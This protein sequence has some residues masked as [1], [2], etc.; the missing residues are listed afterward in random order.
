MI[1][2][3]I[4]AACEGVSMRSFM[5]KVTGLSPAHISQAGFDVKG[6][7]RL[8]RVRATSLKVFVQHL[9][10][11]GYSD[12]EIEDIL[13]AYPE[14]PLAGLAHQLGHA[15]PAPLI[16]A[17][18]FASRV[19]R[20]ALDALDCV[21]QGSIQEYKQRLSSFFREEAAVFEVE[22]LRREA[23]ALSECICAAEDWA[24]L[25]KL[26]STVADYALLAV[27]AAIDVEW[28]ARYFSGLKPVPTLLWLQPRFHPDFDETNSKGLKRDVV[29]RPVRHLLELSWSL[30]RRGTSRKQWPTEPPGP[31]VL[32]R[33]IGHVET[34]DL[35]IR[36]WL[37]GAKPMNFAQAV[38]IWNSLNTNISGGHSYEVPV[39]WLCLALW[40]ERSLIRKKA[41]S[42]VAGSVMVLCHAS[43]GHIWEGHRARWADRLPMAGDLPWPDWMLAQSSSPGW[44]RSSQSLGLSSSPRDCQ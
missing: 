29:A 21:H 5:S 20:L 25:T 15:G 8:Q 32:A 28:G 40:M 26:S 9:S 37:S 27:L 2:Y 36:K 30:A 39:P 35:I 17:I 43:Y 7:K 13:S 38:D 10:S 12:V 6:P 14:T 42:C 33:D 16:N 11:K 44:M 19:D 1:P 24:S 18:A 3:D 22:D 34:S 23:L 4:S 31:S 41:R